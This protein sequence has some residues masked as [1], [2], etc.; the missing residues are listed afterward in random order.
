DSSSSIEKNIDINDEYSMLNS[1]VNNLVKEDQDFI[2][3]FY[4]KG[5][6]QREISAKLNISEA[7][8]SRKHS[9]IIERLKEKMKNG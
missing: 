7:T 4:R 3:M 1:I 2:D 9:K 6:S 8:V 5:F